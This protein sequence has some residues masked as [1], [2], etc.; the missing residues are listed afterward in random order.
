MPAKQQY[1]SSTGQRALK[2]SAGI[3]GG[4]LLASALHLVIGALA[5]DKSIIIMTSA[6]STFFV[7]IFLMIM[8]F[9][10]KSGWKAWGVYLLGI[11]ICGGIIFMAS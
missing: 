4:F 1:L 2:V 5:K 11:I 6:F 7:W 8:A 10:F 9:T 3:L